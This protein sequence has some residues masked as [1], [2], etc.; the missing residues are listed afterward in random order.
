VQQSKARHKE[1]FLQAFSPFIADATS[2]AYKGASSEIQAKLRR[3]VDVWKERNIFE[4]DIQEAMEARLDGKRRLN[5]S[6]LFT[7]FH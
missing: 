7:R 2:L 6:S 1:D 5:F 4:R 3:V